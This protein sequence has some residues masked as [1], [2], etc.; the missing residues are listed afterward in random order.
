MTDDLGRIRVVPRALGGSPLVRDGRIAEGAARW[1]RARPRTPDEWRVHLEA[2]RSSGAG[3]WLEPLRPA[4]RASGAAAERIAR[5]AGGRGVVVTTGQQPGLFGGPLYTWWKA[6][7]A[8]ALADAL[9][10]HTG[11]AVAP[12][13]WAATDDADFAEASAT[14]V[15]VPGGLERLEL[16]RLAEDGARMADVPLAGIAPLRERL[17]AGAGSAVYP[18]ALA[19]AARTYRDGTTVGDAYVALLRGLLEPL[20]V[21]VLDAAH[22]AVRAAGTP[23]LDAALGASARIEQALLDRE[24]DLR[25][26]GFRAQVP[27]VRGRSLVFSSADGRRERIPIAAAGRAAGEPDESRGP[28]VLLRPL[29]ERAILPTAAYIAGPGELAYFAQV[30]AVAQSLGMETPLALPRWSGTVIEP[31]VQRLLDRHALGLESLAAEGAAEG[32]VARRSLPPDV[33]EA[34]ASLRGVVQQSV[35]GLARALAGDDAPAVPPPVLAGAAREFERRIARLDRRIVAAAKRDQS[36]AMRD[37]ATMRAALL[38]AGKPQERMINLLPLLARHGPAL[39]DAVRESIGA[40][41]REL[42]GVGA[43]Q[44]VDPP[45]HAETG[46]RERTH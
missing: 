39:L 21:A 13:F 9:E 24:R 40:H 33:R 34:V 26:G 6:L 5:A 38:P 17:A 44:P 28:N 7:S 19:L 37:V 16:P 10:E 30:S 27:L 46:A 36:E 8:L 11:V 23:L 1:Y 35:D 20:G 14:F 43:E 3:S 18:D 41:A 25:A 29:M 4:I 22:P 12:V 31:H 15:A 42:I 45:R 2:V 32:I